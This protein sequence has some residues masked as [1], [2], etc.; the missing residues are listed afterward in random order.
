MIRTAESVQN[1][2][3][4]HIRDNSDHGQ[5]SGDQAL[6]NVPQYLGECP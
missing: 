2:V 5:G 6:F 4:T 3:E 1:N